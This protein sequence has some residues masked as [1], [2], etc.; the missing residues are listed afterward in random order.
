MP[1][2]LAQA[3]APRALLRDDVY[4]R[5]RAAIVDGT[6]AAGEK[7]KDTE[8]ERWLGVSRTPI[9]EAVQRLE[10]DGLVITRPNKSTLV[11][12]FD[13]ETTRSAQQL[14]SALHELATR[15]AVPRLTP[16]GIEAL[17]SANRAFAAALDAGSADDALRAD[18]EFHAVL[19]TASGN[20]MLAEHLDQATPVIRRVERMRFSSEAA[21]ESVAQHLRIIDCARRG[22][23]DGAASA[24]RDNWL[25]LGHTAG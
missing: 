24:S 5:L 9:R 20:E 21:R 8:L 13:P 25:S 17:E 10:R 2:P 23:A 6:L 4:T 7:L 1:V 19:V 14:V 11:A 16:D 15:L 12:P 18:D 22:D 3:S